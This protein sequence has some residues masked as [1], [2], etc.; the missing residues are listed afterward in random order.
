MNRYVEY[1]NKMDTNKQQRKQLA[2][3]YENLKSLFDAKSTQWLT[4]ADYDIEQMDEEIR[5]EQEQ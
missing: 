1:I 5:Y 4:Q 3:I 2:T